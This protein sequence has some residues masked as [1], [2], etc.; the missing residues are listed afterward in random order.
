M[1]GGKTFVQV[2]LRQLLPKATKIMFVKAV[3]KGL[4]VPDSFKVGGSLLSDSSLS[5]VYVS[6]ARSLKLIITVFL[7]KKKPKANN[8]GVEEVLLHLRITSSCFVTLW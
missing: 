7:S 1:V 2:E 3:L 8:R 6:P 4:L 5:G